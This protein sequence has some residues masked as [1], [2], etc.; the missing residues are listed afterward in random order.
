M[1][2]YDVKK[3]IYEKYRPDKFLTLPIFPSEIFYICFN[4]SA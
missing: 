3:S 1:V 4:V 2:E